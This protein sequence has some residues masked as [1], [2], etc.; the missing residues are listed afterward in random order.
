MGHLDGAAGRIANVTAVVSTDAAAPDVGARLAAVL[1]R[2]FAEVLVVGAE[3]AAGTPGR[4]VAEPS[5]ND[6]ARLVA[7]LEV[8]GSDRVLVATARA[9]E[10]P[11]ALL[12]GLSAWPEHDAVAERR[13]DAPPRCAIYR[14]APTLAAARDAAGALGVLHSALGAVF[15]EGPDLAALDPVSRQP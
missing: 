12:L 15:V 1:E 5:G 13:G 4:F 9:G 10:A 8:A 14:R 11:L 2:C 6:V 3:P 7:A